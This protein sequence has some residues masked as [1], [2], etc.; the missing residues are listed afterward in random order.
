NR[1][2][3]LDAAVAN[4]GDNTVSVFLGKGT[5]GFRPATI[6]PVG[7]KPSAV[8]VADLNG[9]TFFDLVVANSSDATVSVILGNGDG[10]FQP[11]VKTFGT[12][13]KP[14]YVIAADFN[15]DNVVDL[16]VVNQVGQ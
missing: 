15:R 14:V 16:A 6:L 5:G 13:T 2:G 3:N 4:A 11:T 1:D 10:T 7:S 8:A 9:D 12:G